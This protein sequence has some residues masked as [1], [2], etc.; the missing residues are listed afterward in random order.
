MPKGNSNEK[1][2]VHFAEQQTD[3]QLRLELAFDAINAL[4]TAMRGT[5]ELLI[6]QGLLP[7]NAAGVE[8]YHAAMLKLRKLGLKAEKVNTKAEVQC[9]GCQAMLRVAGVAG[10]H[11]EWCGFQF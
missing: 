8:Q 4:D 1:F 7:P 10:D 9:P 3:V 6:D 11:C 2:N 5:F